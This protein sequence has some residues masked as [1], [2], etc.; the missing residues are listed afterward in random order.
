MDPRAG[1]DKCEKSRLPR[2]RSPNRP[3]RSQS[4]YRLRYP[5]NFNVTVLPYFRWCLDYCIKY[6]PLVASRKSEIK[7]GD[8]KG[9]E[10]GSIYLS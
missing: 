10:Y 9:R 6:V 5:A 7:G 3:A 2:I 1:L 8:D 4:L